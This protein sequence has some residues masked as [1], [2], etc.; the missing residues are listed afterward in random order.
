M[1]PR[2][3]HLRLPDGRPLPGGAAAVFAGSVGSMKPIVGIV[4]RPNVGKSTLFNRIIGHKKA[5]TE[6]VPGGN[7]GQ[8]LR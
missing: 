2:F 4:G 1:R 3:P 6:D 8:K 7:Q 5:I